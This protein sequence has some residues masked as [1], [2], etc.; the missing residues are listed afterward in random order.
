M[1]RKDAA[2]DQAIQETGAEK[3]FDQSGQEELSKRAATFLDWRDAVLTNEDVEAV[4][5]MRV[6]SRRLRATL[7]AYHPVCQGKPFKNAYRT[8]KKT[9][10]LL[11]AARD[12]DVMLQEVARLMEEAPDEEEA[13]LHWLRERLSNYRQECQQKL[14]AFLPH[15][16]EHA[17]LET[18]ASALPNASTSEKKAKPDSALD[19]QAPIGQSSRQIAC[20]KVDELSGWSDAVEQPYAVR[21]LHRLRIAAK[22]LRYTLEIFA[23]F[24][25]DE[26]QPVVKELEQI[27]EELGQLHDRDVIIGLLRLCL[28]SLEHPIAP[29]ALADGATKQSKPKPFLPT[30]LVRQLI[31]P[32]GDFSAEQRYGLEQLLSQQQPMR[33]EAY[34]AFRQHWDHLKER[35]TWRRLLALLEQEPATA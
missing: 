25:P 33:K 18:I 10:H 32:S 31:N 27:Q 29:K 14:E 20:Q 11:G 13:G 12:T 3:T 26:C 4:H 1:S 34:N 15:L 19:P 7:D 6:A 22:R 9:A 2:Y 30:A 16:D 8:V 17:F 23:P 24:L 35:D 5:K 28:G 21:E